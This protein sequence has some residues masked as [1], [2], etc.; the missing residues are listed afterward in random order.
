MVY[1][2]EHELNDVRS[3][4]ELARFLQLLSRRVAA[5]ED[6]E[7]KECIA[8]YLEAM[9]ALLADNL[10]KSTEEARLLDQLQWSTFAR[11]LWG[12]TMYE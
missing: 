3:A 6:T 10:S 12:A 8:S 1:V 4:Q 7:C 9:S 5:D 11:L 2:H